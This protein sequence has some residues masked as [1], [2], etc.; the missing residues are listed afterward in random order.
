RQLR[1]RTAAKVRSEMPVP[2]TGP[3]TSRETIAQ[4]NMRKDAS[5]SNARAA[6][7]QL[8]KARLVD[9]AVDS[10]LREN[11]TSVARF[12][13]RAFHCAEHNI[14][15]HRPFWTNDQYSAGP[16]ALELR[17]KTWRLRNAP[18]L[19]AGPSSQPA[20][21]SSK[22]AAADE[23][24][25]EV[26]SGA[27]QVAVAFALVRDKRRKDRMKAGAG[28]RAYTL[29]PR[30]REVGIARLLTLMGCT[31][32]VVVEIVRRD[33]WAEESNYTALLRFAL[34]HESTSCYL[35]PYSCCGAGGLNAWTTLYLDPA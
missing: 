22:T 3:S 14:S 20:G 26:P 23:G 16:G 29:G 8:Q 17:I 6:S 12:P 25:C 32:K 30:Q 9:P 24:P 5:T 27:A 7:E 1:T 18:P 11:P 33:L 31:R 15:P 19:S 35:G 2:L 4:P 21:S 13:L 28:S 10:F 34:S